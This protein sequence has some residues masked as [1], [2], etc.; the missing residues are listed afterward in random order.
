MNYR[1]KKGLISL[2]VSHFPKH[3]LRV[4][5]DILNLSA[6]VSAFFQNF[7]FDDN[8]LKVIV[9]STANQLI[10]KTLINVNASFYKETAS[11]ATTATTLR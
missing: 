10:F 5:A 11:C 4:F 8:V 1:E 2:L 6:A 3:P 9:R 7:Q